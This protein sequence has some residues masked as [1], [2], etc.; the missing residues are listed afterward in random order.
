[1]GWIG[2]AAGAIAALCGLYLFLI[3]PG[4]RRKDLRWMCRPFA[5]RGLHGDGIPENSL[6]AY[7]RAVLRGYGIE[8]DVRLTRDG[9]LI[10][11]HDDSLRRMCGRDA[12]ISQTDAEDVR[13]CRLMGTE[14]P[15]PFLSEALSLVGGRTPLI[16]ELKSAGKRNGELAEKVWAQ[17][18]EY[19]GEYCVESFDPR[20][21]RWF[22]RHAPAVIR[23]QLA[24]DPAKEGEQVRGALVF[25]CAHLMANCLSRPD[26]VAYGYRG[27][28]NVSFRVIRA[29]FHPA[30]AAWTRAKRTAVFLR[31]KI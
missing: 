27:G 7:E 15:P 1:M 16:I 17:L 11:H 4:P 31:R 9:Q 2:W 14:G 23:G 18:R 12:L 30:L 26:F 29:L 13:A 22:R 21:L 8:W 25:L 20:L 6:A 10:L 3:A 5:H 19:P 24:C 28:R